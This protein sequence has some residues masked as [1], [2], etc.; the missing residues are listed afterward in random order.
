M[1][2]TRLSKA[3]KKNR[4]ERSPSICRSQWPAGV[5]MRHWNILGDFTKILKGIFEIQ[6]Q[7]SKRIVFAKFDEKSVASIY[8]INPHVLSKWNPLV[9]EWYQRLQSNTKIVGS[10]T[11]DVLAPWKKLDYIIVVFWTIHDIRITQKHIWSRT[12]VRDMY[13]GLPWYSIWRPTGLNSAMITA[14]LYR[15]VSCRSNLDSWWWT[16][17]IYIYDILSI[18]TRFWPFDANSKR[19]N[20][21]KHF[22]NVPC[23]FH[24]WK[25]QRVDYY[26]AWSNSTKFSE[27][28]DLRNHGQT[29][30]HRFG[31]VIWRIPVIW[32]KETWFEEYPTP[33]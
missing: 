12:K 27:K 6:E 9:G 1:L 16:W 14:E 7:F 20:L 23:S 21:W 26:T 19:F 15:M 22:R 25:F 33:P 13:I 24:S 31:D 11:G 10:S 3:D 18:K 5:E 32:R 29:C 2:I 17:V 28:R 30:G 4:R 8:K